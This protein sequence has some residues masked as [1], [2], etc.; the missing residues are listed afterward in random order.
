V[1][2]TKAWTLLAY[3]LRAD[4][5]VDRG[6]L[7]AL[8]F[9]DAADPAAAL[10]WNLSQ[11]RR[12][13]GVTLEG[14]PVVLTLPVGTRVDL[15][16]LANTEASEAM[17]VA[18]LDGEFLGG[19]SVRDHEPLAMWLDGERRHLAALTGDVLREAA[20]ARLS[21]GDAIGAVELAERVVQ[22]APLDENAAVI[23]V[24]SLREAGR[25]DEAVAV[26]G[27]TA[28]RIRDELGVEPSSLLRSAVHASP[29]GPATI[30]G[31]TAIEA[32]LEAGEAA[33]AAGVPDAGL[34]A[35]REALGGSRVL[36]EPDL[37][38]RCLTGLGSALIHAVRGSDQDGLALLHQA[39]PLATAA[40]LEHIAALANRELGY[41]DLLRG[42]YE[43]AQRWFTEA[44]THADG[45]DEE[46]AWI[47]AFS[48][49]GHT[50]VGD[51]PMAAA[52][53][54][55][56]VDRATASRSDRAVAYAHAMR[57]RLRL[58]D[59]DDSGALE[60]LDRSVD[61]A[62]S[63]M[64]R[65]FA[66][67][68]QTIRAEI[69]YRRGD[70]DSATSILQTALATSRQLADPCWE[71]MALRGLG[72]TTARG[73]DLTEG[74]ELLHDAPRQC[75][76]LPDTYLWIEIYGLDAL[77]DVTSERGMSEADGHIQALQDASV[78]HG[79]RAMSANATRYRDR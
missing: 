24:R 15:H 26:A 12:A 18:G 78:S 76:R 63:I 27:S 6:R 19:V 40:G 45:H 74:L 7:S 75:R 49:M 70:L 5:P 68:P 11:L 54:D 47:A 16:V 57:G 17:S 34:D 2:G 69:A 38:A 30:G 67:W 56:A 8:L 33:L 66:P 37:L 48:G 3:L 14:D 39:I 29:G 43:R 25:P 58:L 23:L 52:V 21:V 61:I 1:R 71:A 28:E 59:D 60:D 44:A 46:R 51:Y 22:M 32:Q 62:R 31:R 42:R 50:D 20:V 9:P 65:S 79:M 4:R 13:L 41:V 55:E 36:A 77:A 73:G 35:L 64:W 53:L 72:L 10:R